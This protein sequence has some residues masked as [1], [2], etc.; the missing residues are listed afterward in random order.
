MLTPIT[1]DRLQNIVIEYEAFHKENYI[2][3]AVDY[4]KKNII[5]KAYYDSPNK[6]STF[7]IRN[8]YLTK[9]KRILRYALPLAFPILPNHVSNFYRPIEQIDALIPDIITELQKIFTDTTFTIDLPNK[10]IIIDWS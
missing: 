3:S 1:R 10:Q 2:N 8:D 4:I 6:S 9:E 5:E 7:I